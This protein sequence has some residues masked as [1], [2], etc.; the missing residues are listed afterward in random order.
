MSIIVGVPLNMLGEFED[1]EVLVEIYD[2]LGNKTGK[3]DKIKRT[4]LICQKGKYLARHN[5]RAIR[6]DGWYGSGRFDIDPCG[7]LGIEDNDEAV[8]SNL[9]HFCCDDIEH[10]VVGPSL[11]WPMKDHRDFGIVSKLEQFTEL[12]P[13]AKEFLLERFGYEGEVFVIEYNS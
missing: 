10:V 3:T 8:D 13:E 1:E 2:K 5:E 7:I 6:K 9:I 11:D 12:I 4:Y